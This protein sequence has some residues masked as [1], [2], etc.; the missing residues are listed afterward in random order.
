MKKLVITLFTVVLSASAYAGI[1]TQ[2]LSDQVR[3]AGSAVY[4]SDN[5]ADWRLETNCMPILANTGTVVKYN[6]LR[7]REGSSLRIVTDGETQFCRVTD[8]VMM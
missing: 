5:V 2:R 8:I 7:L 4:V 3:I 6:Q 1:Y